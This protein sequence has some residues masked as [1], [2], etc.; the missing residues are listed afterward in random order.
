MEALGTRRRAKRKRDAE[1][2]A[3]ELSRAASAASTLSDAG[4]EALVAGLR[5]ALA[6]ADAAEAAAGASAL[7]AAA[8]APS[9]AL[10]RVCLCIILQPT[11]GDAAA[12]SSD[13][14]DEPWRTLRAAV[15]GVTWPSRGLRWAPGAGA[16]LRGSPARLALCCS[17]LASQRGDDAAA[18][19]ALCAMLR[20]ATGRRL[21][22]AS[23][24]LAAPAPIPLLPRTLSQLTLPAAREPTD[25]SLLERGLSLLRGTGAAL[26]ATALPPAEVAWLRRLA[27]ERTAAAEGALR[28]LDLVPFVDDFA[29][30][31][32]AARGAGRI[33]LRMPLSPAP[34]P[35]D[36]AADALPAPARLAALASR[37]C[38]AGLVR[39][40]LRDASP[41]VTASF[42]VSR[43]GAKDQSWHADGPHLVPRRDAWA[44]EA[45]AAA[46]RR[47]GPTTDGDDS[48][49]F[50]PPAPAHAVC[51]FLPL[52]DVTAAL[53][54]TQLWLGSHVAGGMVELAPDALR[55]VA[56]SDALLRPH[57][58]A[59]TALLYDYRLVHRGAANVGDAERPLLQFVYR[60]SV[61]EDG[62]AP[63]W[64]EGANF[65][66]EPL[67]GSD[68]G[69]RAWSVRVEG[70]DAAEDAA[71]AGVAHCAAADAARDAALA[72]ADAPLAAAAPASAAAP[73]AAGW[74]VFD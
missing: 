64:D 11:V 63:S 5:D 47:D 25:A 18:E 28:N 37:G 71:A 67:L 21:A 35:A 33:E 58:A 32:A 72:A 34:L 19:E 29:C 12:S 30:A 10:T 13:A 4:R 57:V 51:V 45:A 17:L 41:H 65:G 39:A 42:I 69:E 62:D 26:V 16:L 36:A 27:A 46:P 50:A 66:A 22:A 7:A 23:V 14:A 20:A 49:L 24:L 8:D 9:L 52:V 61:G 55:E 31:D 68:A 53:G 54:G 44:A 60:R 56:D 40:A 38:W 73:Q 3:A 70:G 1:A 6:A 48:Q 59:G 2:L 43:P 15:R 74:D